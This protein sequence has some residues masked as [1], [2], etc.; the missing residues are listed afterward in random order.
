MAYL[1]KDETTRKKIKEYI[2]EYVTINMMSPSIRDIAEGTGISRSMVQRYMAAMRED[3][4]I[5]YGRRNISTEFTSRIDRDCVVVTRIGDSDGEYFSLPRS[6]VG[7]GSFYMIEAPD[8]S[9]SGIGISEGDTVI[10]RKDDSFVDG[11]CVA[12]CGRDGELILRNAY[13]RINGILLS[14]ANPKYSSKTERNVEIVGVAVKVIKSL[15]KTDDKED[16][17][18][19]SL[20]VFLL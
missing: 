17:G 16:K 20:Q 19:S 15:G 14:A 12:F 1:C 3:G 10:I 6:W 9:M 13:E 8:D 2:N 4:E 5:D 11:D 7:D 18:R